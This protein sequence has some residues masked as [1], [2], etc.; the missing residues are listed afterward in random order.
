MS[1]IPS[2]S[3]VR[4]GARRTVTFVQEL[5]DR[6][7]RRLG[8]SAPRL[9]GKAMERRGFRPLAANAAA[10]EKT[11]AARLVERALAVNGGDR[12]LEIGIKN[13]ATLQAVDAGTA[14]GVDPFHMANVAMCRPGLTVLPLP[15]DRYFRRL[16]SD[17]RFDVVFVDGLHVF[18]QAYRDVL[19][20]AATLVRGGAILIDDVVPTSAAAGSPVRTTKAWMG[21]VYKVI[22]ALD[23]HHPEVDYRV[24]ADRGGHRLA[25]AWLRP[26]LR[27]GPAASPSQLAAIDALSFDDVFGPGSTLQHLFAATAEDEAFGDYSAAVSA[28]D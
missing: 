19:H 23:R 11:E 28:R 17:Q 14:V 4:A 12:Y 1:P 13:G 26:G 21:D 2:S 20:A 6:F 25:L 16:P 24:V 7:L 5:P 18:R 22:I 3:A 15:S 9:V 8:G 10:A 27:I